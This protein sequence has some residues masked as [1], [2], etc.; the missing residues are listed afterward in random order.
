MTKRSIR[1]IL[2][3]LVFI[4]L[5]AAGSA[6]FHFTRPS[7]NVVLTEAENLLFGSCLPSGL[8][9]KYRVRPSIYPSLKSS[10]YTLYS[11]AAAAE[12]IGNG[13]QLPGNS[14]VWGLLDETL[15]FGLVFVPDENARWSNAYSPT[16]SPLLSAV[17][18]NSSSS[19][20]TALAAEAP[21]SVLRF[22]YNNE[23]SRVGAESLES[24][25]ARNGVSSLII[26]S[27]VNTLELFDT[28]EGYSFTVPLLYAD[29]FEIV[30]PSYLAAEDFNAMFR[31]LEE[32]QTGM[33]ETPYTLL[34]SKKGIEVI[35][36]KLF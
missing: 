23:L 16:G 35:L 1:T 11:P 12:A 6:L 32:G 15:P 18:Y 30:A 10:D 26:Y 4:V 19:E 31:I 20:E 22:S 9:E 33:V 27:P 2:I 36:D 3:I 29:V 34:K 21:S 5:L 25:L 28:D 8:F 13:D 24:D 14:A 7:V 17:I